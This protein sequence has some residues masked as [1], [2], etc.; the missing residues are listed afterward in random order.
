MAA[1][2]LNRHMT[3]RRCVTRCMRGA[4]HDPRTVNRGGDGAQQR[5][6][7]EQ[8]GQRAEGKALLT[9]FVVRGIHYVVDVRRSGC[10]VGWMT[11][12]LAREWPALAVHTRRWI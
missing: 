7:E 3:C 11:G 10:A 8:Y 4:N 12:R 5:A 1:E 9:V 2:T 6:E